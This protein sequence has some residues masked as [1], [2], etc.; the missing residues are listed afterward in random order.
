MK[1]K[2]KW[3]AKVY[4]KNPT[5]GEVMKDIYAFCE[6]EED[7]VKMRDE[8]IEDL[9]RLNR[10]VEYFNDVIHVEFNTYEVTL[11]LFKRRSK[12]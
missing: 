12:A 5:T 11:C 8:C 6:T 7:F 4:L 1:K 9:K 2:N 3:Y 10:G